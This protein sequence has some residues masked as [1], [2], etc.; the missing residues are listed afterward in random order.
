[1][2]NASDHSLAL[3]GSLIY[4]PRLW[5]WFPGCPTSLLSLCLLRLSYS[6]E[7]HSSSEQDNTD[8]CS[9]L[10]FLEVISLDGHSHKQTWLQCAPKGAFW[11]DRIGLVHPHL[12]HTFE[13][14]YV[15]ERAS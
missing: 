9:S 7:D 10:Q 2:R 11:T 15:I 6:P 12:I 5:N 3:L 14:M 13:H 4:P 1:M 8:C